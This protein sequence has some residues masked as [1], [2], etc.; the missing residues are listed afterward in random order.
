MCLRRGGKGDSVNENG[1]V[2]DLFLL[3]A[4]LLFSNNE[5]LEMVSAKTK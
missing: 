5:E 2:C 3:N 1:R 4:Q